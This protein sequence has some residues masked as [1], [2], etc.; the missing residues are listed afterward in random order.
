MD[1]R[2]AYLGLASEGRR[3]CSASLVK[4]A[5]GQQ[6]EAIKLLEEFGTKCWRIVQGAAMAEEQGALR[7]DRF[8]LA[9]LKVDLRQE[10]PERDDDF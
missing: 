1:D 8:N 3:I 4:M 9:E 10:A 5:T 6:D 2:A 7:D